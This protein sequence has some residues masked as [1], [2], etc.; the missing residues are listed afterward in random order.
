M[1]EGRFVAENLIPVSLLTDGAPSPPPPCASAAPAARASTG[2]VAARAD[3]A[4]ALLTPAAEA[5]FL[6]KAVATL[7]D[8]AVPRN[9][10]AAE[11]LRLAVVDLGLSDASAY[12]GLVFQLVLRPRSKA[13]SL[14][15]A[16]AG[17]SVVGAGKPP[18][19]LTRATG[20]GSSSRGGG[21][22]D[23]GNV[24]G[25]LRVGTAFARGCERDCVAKGGR[26]D[27]LILRFMHSVEGFGAAGGGRTTSPPAAAQARFGVDK[28]GRT[29]QSLVAAAVS[30]A[31]VTALSSYSA[32]AACTAASVAGC[33][34][35]AIGGANGAKKLQQRGR[36]EEE[37]GS[38]RRFLLPACDVLVCSLSTMP[39]G[40]SGALALAASAREDSVSLQRFACASACW[41]VGLSAEYAHPPLRS[42][43]DAFAYATAVGA[44]VLVLLKEREPAPVAAA[45][46][47]SFPYADAGSGCGLPLAGDVPPLRVRVRDVLGREDAQDV[48]A[49]DAPA[50]A[51]RILYSAAVAAAAAG[52]ATSSTASLLTAGGSMG[53]VFI[54]AAGGL[55]GGASGGS[56][57]PGSSLASGSFFAGG[58]SSGVSPGLSTSGSSVA[59]AAAGQAS[60]AAEVSSL[61][62]ALTGGAGVA[63]RVHVIGGLDG[64]DG[65]G[66]GPSS[67]RKQHHARMSA[68]EKRAS[69]RL[70]QSPLLSAVLV[71]AMLTRAGGHAAA[72]SASCGGVPPAASGGGGASGGAVLVHVVAMDVPWRLVREVATAAAATGGASAGRASPE[73]AWAQLSSR[74]ATDK[75]VLRHR[76]ACKEALECATEPKLRDSLAPVVYYSIPDDRFD[77]AL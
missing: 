27:E 10:L 45:A 67:H 74:L 9:A 12:H 42:F 20:S 53:S 8:A 77:S 13:A 28:L 71:A 56:R 29:L 15:S 22:G 39:L 62:M 11:A 4:E 24:S 16:T 47:L 75:D 30:R 37:A 43:E 35:Y 19:R 38:L 40:S 33:A 46:M 31:G 2:T 23:S 21:G 55:G 58:S 68:L 73:E 70:L 26:Y 49:V 54:S 34:Q 41:G 18:S 3:C 59:A 17:A 76:K 72:G 1:A 52:N 60:P 50:L 48:R 51:V 61:L 57:A 63:F 69:N 7:A 14:A 6:S 36:W 5:T 64:G 32:A 44:R 66:S 65:A 25:I